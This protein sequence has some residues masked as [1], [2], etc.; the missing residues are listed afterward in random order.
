MH[1][2]LVEDERRIADFVC[3]G[4][5]ARGMTVVHADNGHTGYDL[6]RQ[7]GFDAII[8]DIM[9][10][11]RDGLSV[12]KELRQRGVQT[13]VILLTARNELGDRVQGLECGA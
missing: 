7:N 13:P 9:L 6:A 8:L 4:L 12:L 5:G 2:L 10:P 1:I 11:G 3:E